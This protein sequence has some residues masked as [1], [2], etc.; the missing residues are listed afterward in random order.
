MHEESALDLA[1]L[2]IRQLVSVR[3]RRGC[4]LRAALC[5][6]CVS[7][8]VLYVVATLSV[9][10]FFRGKI[11]VGSFDYPVENNRVLSAAR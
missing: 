1:R 8:G 3:G 2:R 7:P 5:L 6:V 11:H 9:H 10:T 4:L